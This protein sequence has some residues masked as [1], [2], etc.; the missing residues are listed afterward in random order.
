MV[1]SLALL[2]AL[3]LPDLSRRRRLAQAMA[4][5]LV[6]LTRTPLTVQGRENVRAGTPCVVVSNHASY[7]DALVLLA[8]LPPCF[9]YAFLAKRDLA[10]HRA[11]RIVLQR[12]GTVLVERVDVERSVRDAQEAAARLRQG[13]ALVVFAEGTL[14]HAAGLMPFHLGGFLAAAQSGASVVRVALRGT[15]NVLRGNQWFPRHAAVA[16]TIGAPIAPQSGEARAF[17]VALA[18]RDAARRHILAHCGEPD[19][20]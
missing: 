20:S 6:W 5:A 3:T 8:A 4:R 12:T 13:D 18:L 11:A 15:R 2:G 1:A 10:R 7:A 14:R 9:R 17:D 16:V 19:L